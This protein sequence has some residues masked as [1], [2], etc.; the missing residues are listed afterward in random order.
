M[1]YKSLYVYLWI[2]CVIGCTTQSTWDEGVD[3]IFPTLNAEQV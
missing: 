1:L 3:L 2:C